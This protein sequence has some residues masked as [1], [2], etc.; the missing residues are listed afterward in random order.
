MTYPPTRRDA[1]VDIVNGHEVADP[2]RWLE[3]ADAPETAAWVAAQASHAEEALAGLPERAWFAAAMAAVVGRPRAGVPRQRGGRWFVNRN[4]GAQAQDVWFMADTLTELE[5]GGEIVL[6][7]NGWSVAGT[8]SLSTFTVSADGRRL[9]YAV[10]EG[11]SDWQRI[12]VRDLSSGRDLDEPDVVAKFS[13]PTWLGGEAFLYTTFDQAVDARGTA[14]AGLGAA[15]LMIHQVGSSEDVELLSFPDDPQALAWGTVTHD[16][17][18]LIVQIVRGTEPASKIW[19]YPLAGGAHGLVGSHPIRVV[20]EFVA[21]FEPIR[22]VGATLLLQTDLDAPLGR[23]V[24][25]DLDRAA[26]A[27]VEFT[28]VIAESDTTLVGVTPAGETLLVARLADAQPT[29]S[30][31]SLTGGQLGDLD[32]PPGALVGLD[33]SPRSSVATVGISTLDAPTAAFAVDVEA[34][35]DLRPLAL[36]EPAERVAPPYTIERAHAV[37]RDGTQV[38]YFLVRPHVGDS[39]DPGERPTLLYGYGGFKAPVLADYR[40]GWSA[41]LAAGGV[42]VLAN[43]R[44]GGEYGTAWHDAG[45]LGAKQN[46]FDDAIAVAEHLIATGVT[47]AS[48][49]AVHGRSNGGLL[50]GAVMTQRPDLFAC[51]L[52]TVGV[53]DMLRFHRFTIGAAW[54]SD[55]GSPDDAADAETLLAYSPLHR[56]REGV[57]YPATLVCTA[58]HDD[59]VVPL[60]SFK[61]AAAL[62]HAQGGTAPILLRVE[63][64]AGHGAGKS[65]QMIAAE[66]ADV[67]AFAAHHTGL[68]TPA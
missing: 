5:A 37:S 17:A 9:A 10:S 48:A 44:G 54:M 60:H 49:L 35:R 24:G 18:W 64:A 7:P 38:P 4:D 31:H 39:G 43:L 12:R 21:E 15:R 66:W 65:Q 63:T 45:R 22:V 52:P 61:F 68:R 1:V 30:V 26:T 8:D 2:Y 47:S 67:L 50:V 59:R 51:A 41:W 33:G 19:A 3:D 27:D 42:L 14:T 13:E 29:V 32:L 53:L 58:D 34:G 62:Q 57:R 28:E 56:V 25:V 6:D 20:D 36:A 11:G 16:E 40:P 23:V 55:Y 46:V